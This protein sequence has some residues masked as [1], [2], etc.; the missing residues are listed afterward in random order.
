MKLMTQL[1]TVSMLST[2]FVGCV[3]AEKNETTETVPQ[4]T[5]GV[6]EA[7]VTL[8]PTENSNVRGKVTFTQEKE[9]VRI[10]ADIQGLK[11]GLHGFHVHEHGDCSAHDG[12][13]AGGHF[14]PTN[15]RHGGPE[16]IE[17]HVGDLGNVLANDDG[18]AHY[19]QLNKEISLNGVNTIIGR[20]I[21]V[22]ADPDDF[23]TQPA[24]NSG[25]RLACGE[26]TTTKE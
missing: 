3:E 7:F 8:L 6:K 2:S 26:I 19:D 5:E 16:S 11:P 4:A 25:A 21:V 20:S 9:G 13:S 18:K 17:H 12:S 10:V 22:H 1:I 15:K 14:N 24:G 23:K